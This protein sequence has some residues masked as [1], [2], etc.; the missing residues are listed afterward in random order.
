MGNQKKNLEFL[1]ARVFRKRNLK[2]SLA[3]RKEFLAESKKIFLEKFEKQFPSASHGRSHRGLRY[4]FA[5]ALMVLTMSGGAMVYANQANVGAD[6]PLYIF[7]RAGENIRLQLAPQNQKPLLNSEFAERRV[8]EIKE[9]KEKD[10]S[11]EEESIEKLNTD[12]DS[13]LNKAFEK[14]EE[15]SNNGNI[16][17][18]DRSK[19]CRSVFRIIKEHDE[20]LSGYP[21]LLGQKNHSLF[22]KNCAQIKK[23]QKQNEAD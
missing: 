6:H 10:D 22:N 1:L 5:S 17:Q 18:T 2:M 12:F 8:S 19:F 16:S 20:A 4:S 3:P 7:K 11:A 21:G 9:I 15:E 23:V 14:F 13:Q